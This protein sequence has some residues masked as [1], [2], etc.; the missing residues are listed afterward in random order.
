MQDFQTRTKKEIYLVRGSSGYRVPVLR[1]C[2]VQDMPD[3]YGS[4]VS[5]PIGETSITVLLVSRAEGCCIRSGIFGALHAFSYCTSLQCAGLHT[6][7]MS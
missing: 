7:L 3:G 2:G 4:T 5:V 6:S 1:H